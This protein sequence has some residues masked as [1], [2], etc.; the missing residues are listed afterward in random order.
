MNWVGHSRHANMT[1]SHG[2]RPNGER[3]SMG[4]SHERY[5][6]ANGAR[7]SDQRRP[8]PSHLTQVFVP[9]CGPVT[10]SSWTTC[11][12]TNGYR[13]ANRSRWRARQFGFSGHT[14]LTSIQ[15]IGL[16][17]TQS[18][19]TKGRR[20]SREWPLDPDRQ[21]RGCLPAPRTR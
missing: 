1:C 10:S 8:V 14:A 20:T 12:A 19:A 9:D 5:G 15:S 7:W 6:R 4:L 2:R 17:Q 21:P 11:R 13:S 3:L 18:N 16:L